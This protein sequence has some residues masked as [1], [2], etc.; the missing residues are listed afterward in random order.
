MTCV[1]Q[2]SALSSWPRCDLSSGQGAKCKDMNCFVFA[3]APHDMSDCV[4]A[5]TYL[6]EYIDTIVAAALANYVV[7]TTHHSL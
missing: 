6:G 1:T 5:D 2:D 4:K 7:T 3:P